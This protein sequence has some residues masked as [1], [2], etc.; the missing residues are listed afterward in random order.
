MKPSDLGLPRKFSEWRP[1]QYDALMKIATSE[2]R[3]T[4]I[5]APTG[6][7]K[8]AMYMG[9]ALLMGGRSAVLVSTKAQADQVHKDFQRERLVEIRGQSNYP[10]R[11]EQERKPPR[12]TTVDQGGCH[13]GV[14]CDY[15]RNGCEYYDTYRLALSGSTEVVV[16][17]YSYWMHIHAFGEGLGKFD[18]L[19]LDEAHAAPEELAGFMGFEF[20]EDDFDY[21]ADKP[22]DF[23]MEDWANWG[24]GWSLRLKARFEAI[25]LNNKGGDPRLIEEAKK[26]KYLAIKMERLARAGVGWVKDV[27]ELRGKNRKKQ[28]RFDPVVPASFAEEA[29]FHGIPKITL[30]S[31]TLRPK[32]FDLL[33]VRAGDYVFEEYRSSF[34]AVRRPIVW[35]PTA[36]VDRRSDDDDFR[37]WLDRID[38]IVGR[39]LDRK[40][41]ILPVS[42]DRQQFILL[43]SRFRH[44]MLDH[45][46]KGAADALDV[47]RQA[48][49]PKVLV[50]P[51]I[52]TGVDLPYEECEYII[53]AKVPFPST[54]SAVMKE[55]TAKD[56]SLGD[57]LTAIELVQ[58][59][60]R[61]MRAEDDWCEIFI[62]DDNIEWLYGK[63]KKAGFI[64]K[65]FQEAFRA[66]Q[67]PPPPMRRGRT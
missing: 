32:I 55:R 3:F 58:S 52:S 17:N 41:A 33:G 60:G 18:N 29:I 48:R 15:K 54:Q 1:Y 40:G 21:L 44:V 13:F 37:K 22:D 11:V 6:S 65:Y 20:T 2:E 14:Q 50:S 36:R 51:S 28:L 47:F 7:G 10:C 31:A 56:K 39:R 63:A 62:I 19:F 26:V 43:N 8:T 66:E 27:V 12:A 30:V 49:A 24:L 5:C 35:I 23:S 45:A 64:P 53:I 57:Y 9:A 42:Y 61:G 59:A 34:P 25:K 16:T 46:R 4:G 38:Q 67:I